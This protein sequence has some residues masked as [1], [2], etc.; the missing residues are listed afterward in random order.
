VVGIGRGLMG[1]PKI[2]LMDVPSP[3]F[4]L[5]LV[6]ENSSINAPPAVSGWTSSA[7]FSAVARFVPQL[8]DS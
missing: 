2:L 6:R 3:A 4:S 1:A 8:L 7:Q 5:F